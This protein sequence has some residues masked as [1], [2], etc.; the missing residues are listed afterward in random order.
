LGQGPFD[1]GSEKKRSKKVRLLPQIGFEPRI[2]R[3]Y[4]KEQTRQAT[5]LILFDKGFGTN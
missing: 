2:C 4:A 5:E 1:A 3:Y